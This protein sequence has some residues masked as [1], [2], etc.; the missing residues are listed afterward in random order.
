MNVH[1]AINYQVIKTYDALQNLLREESLALDFEF[2]PCKYKTGLH[3]YAIGIANQQNAGAFRLQDLSSSNRLYTLPKATINELSVFFNHMFLSDYSRFL[4]YGPNDFF[5]FNYLLHNMNSLSKGT[6]FNMY[7]IQPVLSSVYNSEGWLRYTKLYLA[8]KAAGIDTTGFTAQNPGNDAAV[9][10]KTAQCIASHSGDWFDNYKTKL[11]E[12]RYFEIARDLVEEE[13]AEER[14]IEVSF[15]SKETAE[16]SYSETC[17][18][19]PSVEDIENKQIKD[20]E[21]VESTNNNA[22]E[23]KSAK[24]QEALLD[25]K[26]ASLHESLANMKKLVRQDILLNEKILHEMKNEKN[27]QEQKSEEKETENRQDQAEHVIIPKKHKRKKR[28][29]VFSLLRNNKSEE[30]KKEPDIPYS[31]FIAASQL[32]F[33]YPKSSKKKDIPCTVT[34]RGG[35]NNK[36]YLLDGSIK[37]GKA[38]KKYGIKYG[39]DLR[40]N[41]F[42]L[43]SAHLLCLYRDQ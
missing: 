39:A 42:V 17:E 23:I 24:V 40:T 9:L 32:I 33:H 2:R 11:A 36:T 19:V 7:D 6:R 13:K 22:E 3:P 30:E 27:Q 15:S 12:E 20:A 26:I 25:A 37:P 1:P 16:E 21:H 35:K 38:V 31:G 29:P 4:I 18:P 28:L 14:P 5:C 43:E 10:F 34:V 41:S 8:A